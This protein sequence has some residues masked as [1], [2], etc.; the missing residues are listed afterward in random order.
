MVKAKE[1]MKLPTDVRGKVCDFI[2]E[3]IDVDEK[4]FDDNGELFERIYK[5]AFKILIYEEVFT[6]KELRQTLF[7]DYHV[8]FPIEWFGG[9]N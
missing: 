9:E 5:D 3:Y 2:K 6:V 4:G 8:L 1:F 7:K